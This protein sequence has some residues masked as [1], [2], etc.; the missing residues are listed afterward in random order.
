MATLFDIIKVEKQTKTKN[1]QKIA[2]FILENPARATSLKLKEFSH[3]AGVSEGSIIN[4]AR[5]LEYD[6]YIE[7]KIA[8]A[9]ANT[10][11]P[12]RYASSPTGNSVF[13][14]IMQA[15]KISLEATAKALNADGIEKLA[16]Q[17]SN[18]RGRVLVCGK[19]TSG[20][21]ARILAGYLMRLHIPAFFSDDYSLAVSSLTKDD[22]LIAITYS[23]RTSEI[24]EAVK[25]ATEHQVYTACIT[26]F[27]TSKIAQQCKICLPFASTE[28]EDGEFPIVARLVQLAVCDTLCSRIYN[29]RGNKL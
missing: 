9:Q 11:F 17:L 25:I 16:L 26:A 3:L 23:G 1:W 29:L 21:I 19:G 13:E 22:V 12:D 7:L 14:D 15:T 20:D 8:I 27:E 4:F 10:K 24:F 5:S 2:D 6:G 18:T 28:A